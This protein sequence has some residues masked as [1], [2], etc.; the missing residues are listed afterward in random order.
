[1]TGLLALTDPANTTPPDENK[2]ATA[3]EVTARKLVQQQRGRQK[4]RTT[5]SGGRAQ[6]EEPRYGSRSSLQ[7]KLEKRTIRSSVLCVSMR[8]Q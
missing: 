5:Q 4:R 3:V 7:Y 1:M 2:E 6:A 8:D